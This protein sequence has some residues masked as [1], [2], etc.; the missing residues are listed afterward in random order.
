MPDGP[1]NIRLSEQLD[2]LQ[3]L[4]QENTRTTERVLWII[5]D[6]D[7]GLVKRVGDIGQVTS[8]TVKEQMVL[9]MQVQSLTTN[10]EQIQERQVKVMATQELH[11]DA[12]ND[13]L[14]CNDDA[15]VWYY[16]RRPWCFDC[17]RLRLCGLGCQRPGDHGERMNLSTQTVYSATITTDGTSVDWI[18]IGTGIRVTA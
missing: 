11:N 7:T 8:D 2:K 3:N 13:L 14:K 5:S 4:L 1:D 18:A 16:P 6:P 15:K 17:P 9:A 12:I 10:V